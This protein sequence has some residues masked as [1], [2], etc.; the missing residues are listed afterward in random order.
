[1]KDIT[2][3]VKF[4]NK[5]RGTLL[6]IS[7]VLAGSYLFITLLGTGFFIMLNKKSVLNIPYIIGILAIASVLTFFFGFFYTMIIEFIAICKKWRENWRISSKNKK[8][9]EQML[10]E[11]KIEEI[12]VLY[13]LFSLPTKGTISIKKELPIL[14][15]PKDPFKKFNS[16]VKFSLS[17]QL[18]IRP[19]LSEEIETFFLIGKDFNFNILKDYKLK[20]DVSS[21]YIIF[22]PYFYAFLEKYF[23]KSKPLDGL[24]NF[25]IKIKKQFEE[26]TKEKINEIITKYQKRQ[27]NDVKKAK[28]ASSI[29]WDTL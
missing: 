9:M 21:P 20:N 28:K 3:L 23:K 24:E 12:K 10:S 25:E 7:V 19:F 11:I 8:E 15:G 13:Y 16:A 26:K 17:M 4:L 14:T 6:Y 27:M 1:M 2:E 22:D 29:N 18:H 5:N